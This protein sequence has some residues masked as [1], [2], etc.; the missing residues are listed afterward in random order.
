M[1]DCYNRIRYLSI[2][3]R[4][5]NDQEWRQSHFSMQDVPY[6]SEWGQLLIMDFQE[7][8]Y[9]DQEDLICLILNSFQHYSLSWLINRLSE[10]TEKVTAAVSKTSRLQLPLLIYREGLLIHLP[11]PGGLSWPALIAWMALVGMTCASFI[12]AVWRCMM[13]MKNLKASIM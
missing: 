2:G 4:F 12:G 8:C 5:S 11:N 13:F 1:M 9:Y 10:N 3:D 7:G 6:S